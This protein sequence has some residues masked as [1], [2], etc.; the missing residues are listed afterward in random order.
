MRRRHAP[1][2]VPAEERLD[3]AP[4]QVPRNGSVQAV[5]VAAAAVNRDARKLI[6][7]RLRPDH[8]TVPEC[9]AAVDA[10]KQ[11]ED[12]GLDWDPVAAQAKVGDR[13][14]VDFV[15]AIVEQRPDVPDNLEWYV[16]Q[17]EWDALRWKLARGPAAQLFAAL[18][19]PRATPEQVRLLTKNAHDAI[20]VGTSG[21]RYLLQGVAA[22]Q[23]AEIR[24]RMQGQAIYPFGVQCLDVYERSAVDEHTNESL[25]GTPR[26]VPGAKPGLLTVVSGR[27]GEGK[28]LAL[29]TPI[30]TPSGWTTMGALQAGDEVFDENGEV[31]RVEWATPVMQDRPCYE[32]VFNDGERIVADAEHLWKTS[33]HL[34]RRSVHSRGVDVAKGAVRTTAQIVATLLHGKHANHAVECT[35]PLV[36]PEAELPIDPYLLGVWLGDGTSSKPEI[37]KADA[38]SQI[39]DV[40]RSRGYTVTRKDYGDGKSPT[41]RVRNLLPALR[42]HNLLNNKHI[43]VA[44]LR[45]SIEQRL[46]LLR[47]L[48]DTDGYCSAVGTCYFDSTIPELVKGAHE[49]MLSLGIK[50]RPVHRLAKLN[51][52]VIGDS[53]RFAFVTGLQV[54]NLARKLQRMRVPARKGLHRRRYVT[55]VRSVPSVPVRCIGVSSSTHMFLAGRGMVPTHNSSL[56]AN[57]ALGL[58]KQKRRGLYCAWEPKAGLTLELLAAVDLAMS[59]KRFLQ[60]ARAKHPL[61][62]AELT[63]HAQRMAEIEPYVQFMSNPFRRRTKARMTNDTNLDEVQEHI[64]AAGVD[65]VIFDL[66]ERCLVDTDPGALADALWR[67]QAMAE[68]L[69]FHAIVAAQQNIR[70]EKVRADM[71]PTVETIKGSSSYAEVADDIILIFRPGRWKP[72]VGDTTI[73]FHRAKARYDVE[74][75]VEAQWDGETGRITGGRTIPTIQ[76]GVSEDDFGNYDFKAKRAAR[77]REVF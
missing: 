16:K 43:P 10:M 69:G 65:W 32:V 7:S 46:D 29:D 42:E 60:G 71:R 58:S 6:L 9:A 64:V 54:F 8:F 41:W 2:S 36:L 53:W 40:I 24:Q 59:R 49:L 21:A 35:L 14:D 26:M 31:C 13:L 51:G 4:L 77:K 76:A 75:A 45:G 11:L 34:E 17:V 73:E 63:Q 55:E 48:M 50:T 67:T 37:T 23:A 3:V 70:N 15:R 28:A 25:A 56:L 62:D 30:P 66:W 33:T 18:Q 27:S 39:I 72:K 44:Y 22:K 20:D 52:R 57:I 19:D 47:G 5:V 1:A 68:E 12:L 38:D 61:T 74:F